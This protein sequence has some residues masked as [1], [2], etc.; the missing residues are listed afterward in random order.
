[1]DPLILGTIAGGVVI[2]V[3][4]LVLVKKKQEAEKQKKREARKSASKTTKA[5]AKSTAK[6]RSEVKKTSVKESVAKSEQSNKQSAQENVKTSEPEQEVDEAE[7][8]WS[9]PVPANAVDDTKVSV[10]DVDTLT[11]FNVY[12][13]FG[14]FDKAAESLAAYLKNYPNKAE[15]RLVEELLNLWLEAKKID[16]VAETLNQY[17]NLFAANEVADYVKK[18]LAVDENNLGLRVLAEAR[19]GWT[20][21]QTAQEIGEQEEVAVDSDQ[22]AAAKNNEASKSKT[23]KQRRDLVVGNVPLTNVSNEEK[24]T[25]LAFMQPEQST[26]LLK[27][28]MNYE[29]AIRY[30]NRAVRTAAKPAA[31]L[32][33]ALTLD[34]KTK[35]LK[36]FAEHLWNLYYSLGQSGRQVKERMLG[37]GYNLGEHPLF[38]ILEANQNDAAILRKIGIKLGYIDMSAALKKSRHKNL[39]TETVD[40][41]VEP[42]TPAERV[43]KEAEFLL[44]YGQLE[45][46]MEM[47]EQAIR[48]YPKESQLYVTLFDL[49]ERA[50]EWGRLENLLKDLRT[51]IQSLP[52]EVVLAMSQL[53]QRFNNGSFGR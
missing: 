43:L 11:E 25:V 19:L 38:G 16:E 33:D 2:L 8:N 41:D 28:M 50:E 24:G 53:L 49:Y 37:L 23:K 3:A 6:T 26:K 47:L 29:L 20:V 18:G 17:P 40:A 34:F 21:K 14:Y 9:T 45:Q 32:I 44:M 30:L 13:Q 27:G 42:K 1:M 52:E 36:N 48:D 10:Q 39:V 4:L 51:Q 5:T 22:D 46:S 35:N 15:K 7:W 12:K 31:Y